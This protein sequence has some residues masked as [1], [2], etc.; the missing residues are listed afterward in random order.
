MESE[1]TQPNANKDHIHSVDDAV[2]NAEE[3]I[4]KIDLDAQEIEDGVLSRNKECE[5][6]K[7][8]LS[9]NFESVNTDVTTGSVNTE[10]G[11]DNSSAIKLEEGGENGSKRKEIIS[12]TV[13]IG[14]AEEGELDYEEE[15][16]EE[17]HRMPSDEQRTEHDGGLAD[18]RDVEG[19]KDPEG[20]EEGE[21]VTDNEDDAG[22]ISDSKVFDFKGCLRVNLSH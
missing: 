17:D 8:S 3:K 1:L 12:K 22:A 16:P 10:N 13:G 9:D 6:Q 5:K 2:D 7:N 20:S 4:Q 14:V 21:I 11:N 15:L 18:D 19:D